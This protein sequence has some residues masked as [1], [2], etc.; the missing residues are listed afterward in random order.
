MRGVGLRAHRLQRLV[1]GLLA[2]RADHLALLDEQVEQLVALGAGA[3]ERA[4]PGEP[5]LLRRLGD[6]LRELLVDG[7]LA[8]ALARAFDFRVAMASSWTVGRRPRRAAC[9]LHESQ[10]RRG[11]LEQ[12][13]YSSR[14]AGREVDLA[15]RRRHA[16]AGTAGGAQ[17]QPGT[18]I[19]GRTSRRTWKDPGSSPIRPA[20]PPDIDLGRVR[21]HPRHPR[22]ELQPL[23]R[24][25]GVPLHGRHDHLP[26]ARPP[27]HGLRQ[28]AAERGGPGQGRAGGPDDAQPPAVPGGHLRRAARRASSASTATPCTRR[29]SSSTS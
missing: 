24:A 6:R 18:T 26:G 20:W 11:E 22:D 28:L 19:P 27:V 25:S 5:D 15:R 7:G 2:L 29:A 12:S 3:R 9:R 23:R 1:G 8:P 16:Q 10:S 13:H 21:E 14:P 17:G 4:E